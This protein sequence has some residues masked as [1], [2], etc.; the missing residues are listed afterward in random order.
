MFDS[1]ETENIKPII[2]TAWVFWTGKKKRQFFKNVSSLYIIYI[3]IESLKIK[4]KSADWSMKLNLFNPFGGKIKS[5]TGSLIE[6]I[7]K[8]EVIEF[9]RLK[10]N[11]EYIIE[12][13]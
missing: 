2:V 1:L 9:R 4:K 11:R 3:Y 10:V 5:N 13:I 6:I 8:N 7:T 12:M